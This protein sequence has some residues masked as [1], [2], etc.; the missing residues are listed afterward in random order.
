[1]ILTCAVTGAG[2]TAGRHPGLPVTPAEI[3]TAALE[4]ARAG[5]A[6]VH[7]HVRDPATRKGSRALEHYREVVHRIRDD[8][9]D[10]IINLTTGMGSTWIVD[11]RDLGRPGA[12]SDFVGPEERVEHIVELRPEICSL[13]CGTMN[14]GAGNEIEI[15]IPDHVRTA[16]RLIRDCGVKAEL[17]VFDLGQM[18]LANQLVAEGLV[19]G[20]PLYQFCLGIPGGA[21]ATT[22]AMQGFLGHLPPGADWTAFG[23]SRWEMP[24]VAQSVLLGGHCRVG[25]ED[26]LYLERGRLASN[27]ELVEKAARIIGDL[28]A[29]LLGPAEARAQWGLTP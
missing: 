22:A 23:I 10:V 14:F 27:A 4:A 8:A 21:P 29:R 19:Q 18:V 5:A 15:N 17:E 1:M 6:A 26:N 16:A 7:L 2:D 9:T 3:A 28:G 20:K 24:M 13:D 12:G 25:L 11:D